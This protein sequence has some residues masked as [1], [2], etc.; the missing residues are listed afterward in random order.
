MCC[1]FK[2]VADMI[3]RYT[4]QVFVP[5]NR[6]MTTELYDTRLCQQPVKE[7]KY[8]ELYDTRSSQ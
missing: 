4:F 6:L 7:T 5:L 8:T 3:Q 1:F 2:P